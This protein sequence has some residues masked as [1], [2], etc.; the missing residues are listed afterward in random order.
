MNNRKGKN[1]P[2]DQLHDDELDID[3]S[4]NEASY[5]LIQSRFTAEELLEHLITKPEPVLGRDLYA[6][7]DLSRQDSEL[8]RQGWSA[9]PVERRRTVIT[10]LVD[11]AESDLDWHLGRIL[12]IALLDSDPT[13]RRLA[14]EGLSE[15]T[16]SDLLGPLI[17]ILRNDDHAEVRAAA[18][19][20]LGNFVLAGEL[21]EMDSALAMRAEQVLLETL[22]ESDEPLIVQS[23][24]LES[25]AYSGETGVRQL[26]EDA[27]YSPEETLRISA[28]VAMGRSADVYWRT[29]VRAEL[30]SPSPAMRA[31]AARACGELE[32]RSALNDLLQLLV[33]DS[34]DVRLAAIFALGRVGGKDARDA[35]RAVSSE[36]E[37]IEAEAA[38]EALEELLFAAGSESIS[39]YDEEDTADDDEYDYWRNDD[40]ELGEYEQ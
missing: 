4:W 26:I 37:P 25:I 38:D 40:D 20:A 17:D 36:G 7:S 9:I 11:L 6:F 8:V 5:G 32:A 2:A 15:D 16:E 13:V 1:S 10:N 3:E 28:L 39:L 24:A 33:D 14:V 30:Q 27:Y 35:L 19:A 12:R 29:Y 21:D 31:E 34:Q 18:A 23:R 22:R